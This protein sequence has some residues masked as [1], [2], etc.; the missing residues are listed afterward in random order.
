[1]A[2]DRQILVY[3]QALPVSI[4]GWARK[5]Q[6]LE[7]SEF[8]MSH[9]S[10]VALAFASALG[11]HEIVAAGFPPVLREALAR[12][13]TSCMS[14]PL[15]DDPLEQA[16]FFRKGV[17]SFYHVI[18]G[19]NPDWVFTGAS[20]AGVLAESHKL[21]FQLFQEGDSLYFKESSIILVKDP[22][23]AS[24]NIDV[25]RIKS[26]SEKDVNHEDVLGNS[27]FSKQEPRKNELISGDPKEIASFLSRRIR[28]L[29]VRE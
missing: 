2:P 12:G 4:P 17:E 1:M 6:D 22:G 15:C 23:E 18:V 21:R 19:E 25:R 11:F 7:S 16:S 29:V 10:R 8:R 28:R 27:T 9:S 26:S 14:I 20:L 24:Q 3:V 5:F 13:A